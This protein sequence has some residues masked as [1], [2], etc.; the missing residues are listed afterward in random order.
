MTTVKINP[1]SAAR[2][3]AVQALYQMEM[4]DSSA[5]RVITEFRHHRLGQDIDGDIYAK[6]DEKLFVD[7][8]D[9]V[10]QQRARIDAA[11]E[12]HLSDNWSLSR[13][14]STLRQLLR[15]AGYEL[16]ARL[17]TP[18][19]VVINEY[20]EVANAFVE[21]SEAGFINGVL[22]RLAKSLRPAAA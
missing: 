6:A 22:D 5:A 11:V 19:A 20:V 13:I 14:D 15:A 12:A 17:D 1:R 10:D 9:G 2:L 4:S 3:A 16:M 8:V 7:I 18:T 21:R